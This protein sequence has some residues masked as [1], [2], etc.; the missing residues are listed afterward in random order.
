MRQESNN[1][2]CSSYWCLHN[3]VLLNPV[4]QTTYR[5]PKFSWEQVSFAKKPGIHDFFTEI[6]KT[7]CKYIQWLKCKN[8]FQCISFFPLLEYSLLQETYSSEQSKR[9]YRKPVS[10]VR[11]LGKYKTSCCQSLG[12]KIKKVKEPWKENVVKIFWFSNLQQVLW[13]GKQDVS[14]LCAR[15][16]YMWAYVCTRSHTWILIF[17]YSYRLKCHQ[18]ENL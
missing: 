10:L 1:F 3:T 18:F 12:L 2:F 6:N 8:L 11:M 14:Y 16:W 9:Q 5:L 15:N 17:S 7:F 13:D 4:Y